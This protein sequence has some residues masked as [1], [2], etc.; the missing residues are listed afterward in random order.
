VGKVAD[1]DP[2]LALTSCQDMPIF[3]TYSVAT[4]LS[5]VQDFPG[6]PKT[7]GE[8]DERPFFPGSS[9]R[10]ISQHKRIFFLACLLALCCDAARTLAQQDKLERMVISYAGIN[11]G[12]APLWIAKELNLFEK[13]GLDARL[14]Q[15][16]AGTTSINALIA[17]DVDMAMTTSSAVVAAVLRDAPLSIVATSGSPAYKL[18]AHPTITSAAQLKGKVVGSSQLGSGADFAIRKLLPKMGL[19][20]GKDVTILPTGLSESYKR[21][22]LIFQGRID[23][24]LG[25]IE[26]VLHLEL[27]GQKVNV[28]ADLKEMGVF[29]SGTDMSTSRQYLKNHPNKIRAFLRAYI[30]GVWIGTQSREITDR[31]YRKYL[32]IDNP[33]LLEAMHRTTFIAGNVP[34]KPYPQLE[35]VQSDIEYLTAANPGLKAKKATEIVDTTL[36]KEIENDGF[37]TQLKK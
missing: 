30:E 32:K 5:W 20:P 17:G 10:A 27:A 13:H 15:I 12:R 7:P 26:N 34:L 16:T 8:D 14:V 19:T 23:A 9:M 11:S 1:A 28:L 2:T 18:L 24:T 25:T 35:S 22:L 31:I 37:Y 4:V 6:Q 29:V 33:K 3:D 21:A 36:L